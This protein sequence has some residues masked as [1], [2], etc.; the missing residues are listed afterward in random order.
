MTQLKLISAYICLL[1][2][3]QNIAFQTVYA[4]RPGGSSSINVG[5]EEA[6][7]LED[8]SQPLKSAFPIL[9]TSGAAED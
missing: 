2:M 5:S 8:H 7:E 1:V 9:T 4:M 6:V 3:F